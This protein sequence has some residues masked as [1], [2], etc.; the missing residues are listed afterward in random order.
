MPMTVANN[1]RV[2]TVWPTTTLPVVLLGAL[3]LTVAAE[4]QEEDEGWTRHF[5]V[6]MQIGLNLKAEFSATGQFGLSGHPAG[7]AG[8]GDHIYDDGY[9]K[10][11][12]TGNAGGYTSYWGY[13]SP[14][15]YDPVAHTL[16]LH[17][18]QS[19]TY[20][21][22]SSGKDDPY[23]GLDAAYGGQLFRWGQAQIG[24]ELGFAFLP[25]S[26]QGSHQSPS[27]LNRTV[28]TFDT[29]GIVVPTAPYNGGP[30]GLGPLIQDNASNSQTDTVPGTVNV[31]STLDADLYNIRLGPT[32][33][34][35]FGGRWTLEASAGFAAG[36]VA[37]DCHFAESIVLAD[38]SH[39]GG[40]ARIG[41]TDFVYGGY[42]A[43][44]LAYRIEKQGD[45]YIGAQFMP[46]GDAL[47]SGAG[48]QARLDLGEG[49]YL[50]AG[51]H[52][53]F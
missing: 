22:N 39:A 16:T 50:S 31:T 26:I 11:D 21:G 7:A 46:M 14:S 51:L 13:N 12:Q 27:V 40:N 52:W 25:I 43:A 41:A 17:S 44:M 5:R 24:W 48:R 1:S 38:G 28:Q 53:P 34:W 10:V 23:L 47:V 29:G 49:V 30:S 19:F 45:I 15:Q 35:Q 32:A 2:A 9:V 6:G 20:N 36:I 4:D 8:G 3:A 37:A 18:A 42:A 33:T